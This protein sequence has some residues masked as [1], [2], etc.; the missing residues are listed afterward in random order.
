VQNRDLIQSYTPQ[1]DPATGAVIGVFEV[2][3]D[4][5][6]LLAEQLEHHRAGTRKERAWA[7]RMTIG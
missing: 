4:V 5:T 2:Y 1:Y 3:S 6:P 7:E